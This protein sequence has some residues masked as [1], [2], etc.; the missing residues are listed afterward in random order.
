MPLPVLNLPP[1]QHAPTYPSFMFFPPLRVPE[2]M[3]SLSGNDDG[4]GVMISSLSGWIFI[5]FLC[6]FDKR[7][8]FRANSFPNQPSVSS[9]SHFVMGMSH[10]FSSNDLQL[11]SRSKY[12]AQSLLM[13]SKNWSKP[14]I[15]YLM[16]FFC[17]F[18]RKKNAFATHTWTPSL[19][20]WTVSNAHCSWEMDYESWEAERSHSSGQN[21]AVV[22]ASSTAGVRWIKGGEWGVKWMWEEVNH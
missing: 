17:L 11:L 18:V 2:K 10:Y 1:S 13:L 6:H 5:L 4:G 19:W 16:S 22:A 20:V 9:F 7:G 15:Y 21:M 8:K 3:G 12:G 14:A